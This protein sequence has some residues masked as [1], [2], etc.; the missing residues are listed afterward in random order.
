MLL[1]CKYVQNV[2]IIILPGQQ[3]LLHDTLRVLVPSQSKP[4]HVRG[5]L[6]HVL[7]SFLIPSPHVLLH[8]PLVHELH[9][10]STIEKLR[11]V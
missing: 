11:T 4:P 7:V 2:T 3:D 9:P 6:L 5:G 8:D 10:P 1:Q